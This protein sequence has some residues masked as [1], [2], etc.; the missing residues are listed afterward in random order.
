MNLSWKVLLPLSMVNVAVVA[1]VDKLGLRLG[2][3]PGLVASLVVIA[4]AAA[5]LR[6]RRRARAAAAARPAWQVRE[7]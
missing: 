4:V 7:A 5:V 2:F 3:L 6:S 1:L